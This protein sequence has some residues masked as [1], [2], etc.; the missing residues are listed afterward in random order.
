MGLNDRTTHTTAAAVSSTGII[1]FSFD[2]AITSADF[3]SL[4]IPLTPT[5]NKVFNDTTFFARGGVIDEDAL[6]KA[7]DSG[8]VA[9]AALDVFSEKP[10]ANDIK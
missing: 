7:L 2:Q 9:Q 5:T 6:F 10:P 1:L 8:I 3:I 4:Y